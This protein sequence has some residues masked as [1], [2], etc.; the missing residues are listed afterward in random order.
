ML[1]TAEVIMK[2]GTQQGSE[3]T[4]FRRRDQVQEGKQY[5]QILPTAEVIMKNDNDK[6]SLGCNT[7]QKGRASDV[8]KQYGQIFLTAVVIMKRENE[9]RRFGYQC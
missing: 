1:P 2:N 8:G 5:G 9:K 3:G 6:R 4:R 7:T